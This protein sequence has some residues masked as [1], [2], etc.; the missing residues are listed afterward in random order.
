VVLLILCARRAL[1]ACAQAQRR[2]LRDDDERSVVGVPLLGFAH[3][4]H[5]QAGVYASRV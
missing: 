2:A 1:E 3:A 4:N 5:A